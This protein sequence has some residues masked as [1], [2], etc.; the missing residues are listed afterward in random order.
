MAKI[1]VNSVDNGNVYINGN[2]LLGRIAKINLGALETITVEHMALGMIGE[3]ELPV[4][5]KKL[6]GE[7]DFNAWYEDVAGMVINPFASVQLM[8]RS[9]VKTTGAQGLMSENPL[10][11]I[12]TASFTTWPLGTQE[13]RKKAEYPSKFSATYLKQ[14]YAGREIIEIDYLANI[15]KVKGVD[16]LAVFRANT[17]A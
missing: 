6:N 14:I 2:N 12:L 3:I 17:G 9:N 10:V 13:P 15:F 1:E 7:I 11:T 8:C 5:F 16:Q 4:G